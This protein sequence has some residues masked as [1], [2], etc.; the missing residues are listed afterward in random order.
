MCTLKP[1]FDA[2]SL[3]FLAMKIVKG[4]IPPISGS[5]SADVRFLVTKLLTRDA[6]RRPNINQLLATPIMQSRIVAFL[7]THVLKE[8]FSHTIVHGKNLFALADERKKA[9]VE[10]KAKRENDAKLTLEP[11]PEMQREESISTPMSSD[12]GETKK[13]EFN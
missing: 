2:Q 13:L 12:D 10:L 6:E 1:P 5:Y 7:D 8:E 3:H 11:I 9:E 4:A